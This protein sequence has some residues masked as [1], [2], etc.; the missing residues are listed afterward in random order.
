VKRAL[1]AL[2]A[3]AATL[4]AGA[5]ASRLAPRAPD[6]TLVPRDDP[7][8]VLD[9]EVAAQFGFENP[10]AWVLEARSGTVWT[11][12]LLERL[13]ALTDDV[14]RIPGVVGPDVIGL[15]S[16]NMRDLRVTAEGLEPT[17][18]MGEVPKTAEAVAALRRRIDADP[19][20]A[21]TLVR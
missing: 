16:P 19:N 11:P 2:A 14:R 21:G 20:Y 13:A 6:L 17:Y 15:A 9:R 10:V 4:A 8:V 7:A 18:L 12:R 3:V 5:A 1:L